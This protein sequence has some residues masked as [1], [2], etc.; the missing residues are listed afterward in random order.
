MAFLPD[1]AEAI[2]REVKDA[3]GTFGHVI[4]AGGIGPTVDDVTI[5]GVA[6]ALGRPVVRH[7]EL[8]ARMRRW[9]GDGVTDAHLKMAEVPEDATVV[10]H[11][12]PAG[13][14]PAPR[15]SSSAPAAA[16]PA[17]ATAA[18]VG[19]EW[20]GRREGPSPFPLVQVRNV[21]ILPGVPHLL[22]R[23]WPQLEAALLRADGERPL[24]PF[25][26]V[27]LRL[28]ECDE[29]RVAPALADAQ[30]RAGPEAALGSY[31]VHGE[32][33]GCRLIIS[34]EGKN[35]EL[36][37]ATARDMAARLPPSCIISQQRG[38][39]DVLSPK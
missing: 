31:P 30:A 5:D 22:R 38:V 13:A 10:L 29:T 12:E 24:E 34:V 39:L 23:K 2:A 20:G 7:K 18:P 15:A 36:V 4:V 17:T 37:E 33:D 26:T 3:M 1:D 21:F 16:G 14:A 6:K 35:A 11:D 28:S 19:S 25:R 9:F 27:L 32:A 8:E